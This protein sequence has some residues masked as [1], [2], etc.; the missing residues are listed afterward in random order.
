MQ[1]HAQQTMLQKLGGNGVCIDG[2]HGTS[3]YD[4]TLNSLLIVDEFG[5]GFPVAWYLSNHKDANA[6]RIFFDVLKKHVEE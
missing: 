4:F 6:M 1:T 5:S 3:A 2:T